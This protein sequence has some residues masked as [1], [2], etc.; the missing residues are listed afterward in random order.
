MKLKKWIKENRITQA[1][2]A[3]MIGYDPAHLSLA[4]NGRRTITR[5][6]EV[7]VE[8]QTK[9]AVLGAADILNE[10]KTT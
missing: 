9:A 7:L 3:E 10:G 8:Y 2:F 1:E 4:M 5:R 6:F